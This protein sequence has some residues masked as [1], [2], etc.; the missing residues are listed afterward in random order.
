MEN[1]RDAN[2][3]TKEYFEQILIE[4]RLIGAVEPDLSFSVFDHTF[5]SPLMMPAYSHQG[6]AMLDYA[7]ISRELNLVHFVGMCENQEFSDITEINPNTIRII[8]P[9][10][11]KEKIF[12]QIAYAQEHGALAVGMDIDHVFGKGGKYDVIL[13]EEMTGQTKDDLQSYISFSKLPFVI[14]GVLS[15]QDALLAEEIGAAAIMVSHHHGRMP[16]AIPP[17]RILP[18]IKEKIRE[19]TI[20]FTDCG[21]NSGANAYKALAMG[22]HAVCIGRDMRSVYKE[23]GKEA[24]LQFIRKMNQE[25]SMLMAYTGVKNASC[26]DPTVLWF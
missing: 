14:K 4:E 17:V 13:H 1:S 26:F 20:V 18:A 8:K 3:G 5:S 16:Y 15:V 19:N 22:S 7:Q 23:Q 11:D 21:I 2:Q 9:Y 10:K 12:D 25:L 24:T 6:K